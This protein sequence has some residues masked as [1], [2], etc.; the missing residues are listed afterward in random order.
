MRTVRRTITHSLP[1]LAVAAL[2]VAGLS[3]SD[4]SSN[5]TGPNNLPENPPLEDPSD[6]VVTEPVLLEVARMGADVLL[7]D[8]TN[9][10]PLQRSVLGVI[11]ELLDHRKLQQRQVLVTALASS[12]M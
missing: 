10:Q 2:V 9:A 3:C 11:E 5:P 6:V 12:I 4:D 8:F 7:V 1:W